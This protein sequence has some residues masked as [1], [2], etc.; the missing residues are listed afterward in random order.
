MILSDTDIKYFLQH[1]KIKITPLQANHIEP[2]S[3]DLTLGNH[4]LFPQQPQGGNQNILE[5]FNYKEV[6]GHQITL[7]AKSF[8]LATTNEY[9]QLNSQLAAF[10]EGRSSIGRAGLFIQNAGWVDPGFQGNITLELYNANNFSLTIQANIRICQIV[11]AETQTPS[12]HLYKGKYQGQTTTTG[13]MSFKDIEAKD[14]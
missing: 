8:V 13:S 9:I 3:I 2:A 4:Y 1:E 7:P 5:P 14:V 12:T 11:F 10:I 6:Q